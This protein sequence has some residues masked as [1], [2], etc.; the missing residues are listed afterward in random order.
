MGECIMTYECMDRPSQPTSL[1]VS[2]RMITMKL[3]VL[4][5]DHEPL[6]PLLFLCAPRF[7]P[8]GDSS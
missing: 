6:L 7:A 1:D 4:F 8:M 2:S 5:E 3:L